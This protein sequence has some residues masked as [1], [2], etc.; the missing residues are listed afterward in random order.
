MNFNSSTKQ[1]RFKLHLKITKPYFYVVRRIFSVIV[2][3]IATWQ[4]VGFF[5]YFEWEHYHIRKDIKRALKHSVPENQLKEFD[6]TANEMKKLTWVKSHEFKLNNHFYDVI[7]QTHTRKGYHLKCID[8]VQETELFQRL[9][10][11][12][13]FN[14]SQS[15]S[16]SPLKHWLKLLKTPF[17]S[18]FNFAKIQIE[19]LIPIDA[20]ALTQYKNSHEYQYLKEIYTPPQFSMS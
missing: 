11:S 16:S 6:F 9:D 1:F 19:S 10:E 15:S 14:L 2:L 5:T 8:D 17:I 12:T 3:L 13:A 18:D 4:I 7:E 20:L